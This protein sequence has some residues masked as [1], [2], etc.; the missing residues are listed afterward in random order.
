M[1][2]DV[3]GF[4]GN[5]LQHYDRNLVPLLFTDYAADISR[6]AAACEP[7]RVLELAAGTEI[8]TRHL[9]DLLPEAATLTATDLNL[10][11]AAD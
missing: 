1:S 11:Q 5:I 10:S 7:R 4:V 8:V 6:R 9:R 2:D 3:A